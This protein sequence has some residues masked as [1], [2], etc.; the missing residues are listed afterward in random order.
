[1]SVYSLNL[2]SVTSKTVLDSNDWMWCSSTMGLTQLLKPNLF[3][4]KRGQ[5]CLFFKFPYPDKKS[6]NVPIQTS[7][8]HVCYCLFHILCVYVTECEFLLSTSKLLPTKLGGRKRRLWCFTFI[9]VQK[10]L[11]PQSQLFLFWLVH[12]M[13]V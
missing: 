5:I 9:Q 3:K 13:G 1:M 7:G 11:W 2:E 8:F 10:I 12:L 4:I 6:V